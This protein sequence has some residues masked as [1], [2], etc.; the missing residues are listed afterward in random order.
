MAFLS[1]IILYSAIVTCHLGLTE[2]VMSEGG[3]YNNIVVEISRY[4]NE[5]ECPAILKGLKVNL[6]NIADFILAEK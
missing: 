1:H 6:K 4:L 3:G 2:I 5:D